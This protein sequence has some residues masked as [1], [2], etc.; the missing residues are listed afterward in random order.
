MGD[1]IKLSLRKQDRLSHI[2]L[3]DK[4]FKSSH[5]IKAFPLIFTY[6]YHEDNTLPFQVLVSV[7]KRRFNKAVDRNRIK[8]L[9]KECFRLK[10]PLFLAALK[11]QS[12][13]GA[14]IYTNKEMPDFQIIEKSVNKILSKLNENPG[15]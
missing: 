12:I 14:F 13:Y 8:R 2:K 9:V 5:S 10:R 4:V 11:E 15:N 3:I 6:N 7:P 1:K